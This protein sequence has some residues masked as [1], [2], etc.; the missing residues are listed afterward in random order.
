MQSSEMMSK[1]IAALEKVFP[2]CGLVL[3]VVP[4]SEVPG[5]SVNYISNVARENMRIMLK[6][7]VDGWDHAATHHAPEARQ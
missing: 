2:G 3:L 5:E 1:A 4:F 7:M 6:E